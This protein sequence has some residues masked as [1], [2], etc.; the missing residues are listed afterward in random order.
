MY[1]TAFNNTAVQNELYPPGALTLSMYNMA[2]Q[3]ALLAYATA[4][5]NSVCKLAANMPLDYDENLD[6]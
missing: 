6:N 2:Y 1:L 4:A 5:N 3:D